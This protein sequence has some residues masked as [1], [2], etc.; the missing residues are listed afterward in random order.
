LKK[1]ATA[2]P[3]TELHIVLDNYGTHKHP[4]IRRWL[5]KPENTRITLHSHTAPP[6]RHHPVNRHAVA[7]R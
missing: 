5:A 6:L 7:H 3:G 2:H 4:N 1:A